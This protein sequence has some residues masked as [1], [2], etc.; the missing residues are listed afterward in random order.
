MILE[1]GENKKRVRRQNAEKF[2]LCRRD[3]VFEKTAQKKES[4]N[5]RITLFKFSLLK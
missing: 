3:K 4:L 5:L 2:L 1:T